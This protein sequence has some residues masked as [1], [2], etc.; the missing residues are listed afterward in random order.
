MVRKEIVDFTGITVG[1]VLMTV[2]LNMFLTPNDI[3][4]GGISGLAIIVHSF[5][6]WPV[7]MLTLAF[8]I[9]LFIISILLLGAKFG[10]KTFYATFLLGATIDLMSFLPVLTHDY[11]LAGVYGGILMGIGLGMVFKYNATTGGTDLAAA[12]LKRFFPQ[13]SIGMLLLIIDAVIIGLAGFVFS[14]EHALY[15]LIADAIAI[16]VID[17]IQEGA[18]D[19]RAAYVISD[20]SDDIEAEILTKLGRGVTSFPGRGGYTGKERKVLFCV[21]SKNEITQFKEIVKGVDPD[22]FVVIFQ[23]HEIMGEGFEEI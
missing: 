15:A 22:A 1:V 21:I 12:I 13:V 20:L 16:R 8:N 3:A 5:T 14:A 17:I 2:S 9:P 7:G 23:A 10:I 6:G 4:P 19:N 18:N 11:L